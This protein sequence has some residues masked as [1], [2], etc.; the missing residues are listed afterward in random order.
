[1]DLVRIDGKTSMND[2]RQALGMFGRQ[3]IF[4]RLTLDTSY[5]ARDD[6]RDKQV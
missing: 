1:M 2:I 5:D 6:E 4:V 3:P